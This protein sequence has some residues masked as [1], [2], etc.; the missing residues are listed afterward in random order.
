MTAPLTPELLFGTFTTLFSGV[1]LV[2]IV[3]MAIQYGG[4]RQRLKTVEDNYEAINAK[5][6]KILGNGHPSEFVGRREI[7]YLKENADRERERTNDEVRRHGNAMLLIA[8]RVSRIES[9]RA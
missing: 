8:D 1:S 5:L 3:R 4:D 6:A 2:F 9:A 7:E